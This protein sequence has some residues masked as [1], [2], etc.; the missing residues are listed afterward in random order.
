MSE[1]V[2]GHRDAK[3]EVVDANKPHV[4]PVYSDAQNFDHF[5]SPSQVQL[6]NDRVKGDSLY[7]SPIVFSN[8]F[9]SL[10]GRHAFRQVSKS[11]NPDTNTNRTAPRNVA[12][13]CLKDEWIEQYEPGVYITF[14]S[15]PD[16][17]KGLKRVR[18][19]YFSY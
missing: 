1:K 4:T 3:D 11:T 5:H 6:P 8:T 19:R 10:Y 15:L 14:T 2:T 17:H 16:G 9:K 13:N 12:A 7:N 18:F